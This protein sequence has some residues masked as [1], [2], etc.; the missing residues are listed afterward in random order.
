MNLFR[1]FSLAASLALAA[2]GSSGGGEG[3]KPEAQAPD[4]SRRFLVLRQ[5]TS[6][7]PSSM[8]R[9][10]QPVTLRAKAAWPM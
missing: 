4:N 8:M 6:R 7:W 3:A 1:S 10:S 9:V 5:I 2:C